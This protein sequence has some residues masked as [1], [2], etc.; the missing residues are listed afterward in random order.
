MATR[1][2]RSIAR[3]VQLVAKAERGICE[4]SEL[5]QHLDALVVPT[6]IARIPL[7]DAV[8]EMWVFGRYAHREKRPDA[9]DAAQTLLGGM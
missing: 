1:R 8:I 5:G 9:R 7:G 3:T 6:V 4:R 2:A